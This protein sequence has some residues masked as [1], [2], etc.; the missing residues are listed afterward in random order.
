MT[1]SFGAP[2]LLPQGDGSF[3]LR[4]GKP[5]VEFSPLQFA[6]A[7]SVSRSTVYRLLDE[8]KIISYRRPSPRK[9]LI[10]AEAVE[11]FRRKTEDPEFWQSVKALEKKK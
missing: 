9:I 10:P 1:L 6:R 2:T 3:V 5:L 8:W 4:P 11:S 7:I